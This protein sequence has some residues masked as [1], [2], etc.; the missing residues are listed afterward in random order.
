MNLISHADYGVNESQEKGTAS[1]DG[2][3]QSL[4]GLEV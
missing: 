3:A 4:I 2:V 1:D